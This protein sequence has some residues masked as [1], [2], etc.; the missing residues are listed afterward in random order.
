MLTMLFIFHVIM[1]MIVIAVVIMV[2]VMV[3]V[4]IVVVIAV[5]NAKNQKIKKKR[6]ILCRVPFL[7]RVTFAPFGAP[8][9]VWRAASKNDANAASHHVSWRAP[10]RAFHSYACCLCLL[11]HQEKV[12][13]ANTFEPELWSMY[14]CI[15][16][17][18]WYFL[19][20]IMF[21]SHFFF[22]CKNY[23]WPI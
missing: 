4:F 19:W 12:G 21:R 11:C 3:K 6:V 22:F 2:V 5:W 14:G 18:I 8:F 10:R 17:N 13:T 15:C 9:H 7:R 20:F 1:I 23:V 16:S